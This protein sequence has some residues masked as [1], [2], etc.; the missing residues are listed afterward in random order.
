MDLAKARQ[1]LSLDIAATRQEIREAY[2]RA[3]RQWHPDAAAPE[4][5]EE[6]HRRML[7]INE[8]Y[9]YIL[10]FLGK[11][12]YRLEEAPEAKDDYE[13]WWH[14]HFGQSMGWP[15]QPGRGRPKK[16]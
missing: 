15:N 8:A 3:A 13:A 16:S 12:R 6:C 2:R 7:E 14:A 4:Q 5:G 9:Q 11:Y 1:L 10:T